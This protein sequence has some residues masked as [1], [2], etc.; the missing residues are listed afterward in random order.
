M[1]TKINSLRVIN[2]Y[3]KLILNQYI[4]ISPTGLTVG[5]C[6]LWNDDKYQI[7]ICKENIRYIHFIYQDNARN[8]TWYCMVVYGYPH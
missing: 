6:L 2:Y 3:N 5:L 7:K 4:E 8:F 1:E